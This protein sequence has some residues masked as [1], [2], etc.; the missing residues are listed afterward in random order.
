MNY[1][2]Q[3]GIGW[4]IK[5]EEIYDQLRHSMDDPTGAAINTGFMLSV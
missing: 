1:Y 4:N 2:W 5:L 3:I